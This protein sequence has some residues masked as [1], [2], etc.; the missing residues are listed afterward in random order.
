MVRNVHKDIGITPKAPLA[1]GLQS[2]IYRLVK[3]RTK[4]DKARWT[5]S[6]KDYLGAY[7]AA[8][9]AHTPRTKS[10]LGLHTVLRNA[11]D[12]NELFTFLDHQNLP[13]NT[14]AIESLNRVLREA[15]SR[16]RGMKLTHR[17][18]LVAWILLFRSEPDLRIIRKHIEGLGR[19]TF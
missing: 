7:L 1:Q 4:Q 12:R 6:W 11:Y 18:A 3:V 2:L 14:N 10:F 9:A 5:A 15:L 16:H 13:N 8:G 17:E 19:H